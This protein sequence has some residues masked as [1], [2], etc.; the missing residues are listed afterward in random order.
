MVLAALLNKCRYRD[1]TLF[2]VWEALRIA[3]VEGARA[4]GLGD[5]VGSLEKGKQA[6]LI[7]VDLT[8]L[9]LTPVLTEPI[10]NIIPNLV[11]VA[12]G[13]VKRIAAIIIHQWLFI[14]A[15]KLL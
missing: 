14:L 10:C 13:H 7:L 2:P 6:D 5:K 8:A 4:I 11:Y 9:N 15:V 1:P 3:T 12:S